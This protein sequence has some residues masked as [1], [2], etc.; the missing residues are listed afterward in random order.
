MKIFVTQPD[1]SAHEVAGKSGGSVMHSLR[2]SSVRIRAEC[3]GAMAC[4]G[5]HVVVDDAWIDKV[6]VA[7]GEEADLLDDSNYRSKGSRLCCQIPM[8]E[9]LD[10]LKVALQLDAY[11]W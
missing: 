8:T 10:G 5:C 4:G 2:A 6:G 7:K 1:G 11:E 3:G 9:R